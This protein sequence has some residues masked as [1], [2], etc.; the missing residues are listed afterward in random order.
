MPAVY[1]SAIYSKFDGPSGPS[2]TCGS[3]GFNGVKCRCEMTPINCQPEDKYALVI[4][5]D[6]TYSLETTECN[7]IKVSWFKRKMIANTIWHLLTP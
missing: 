7:Y 3:K 4:Q 5:C 1:E 6:N 2:S